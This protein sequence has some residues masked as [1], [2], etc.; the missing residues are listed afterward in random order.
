M[1]SVWI[2]LGF[3]IWFVASW[4]RQRRRDNDRDKH[5]NPT[6]ATHGEAAIASYLLDPD[7]IG[8]LK[9]NSPTL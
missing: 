4:H 6:N 2:G 9:G 5:K 1:K 7:L 8:V 3:L